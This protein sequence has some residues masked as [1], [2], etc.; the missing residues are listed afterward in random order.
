MR[1][2]VRRAAQAGVAL[3]GPS[4]G[5]WQPEPGRERPAAGLDKRNKRMV[6]RPKI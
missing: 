5:N 6:H 3:D 2:L 4:F 1:R